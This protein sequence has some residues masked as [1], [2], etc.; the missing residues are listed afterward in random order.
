M[1]LL[2][3]FL[4]LLVSSPVL[5]QPKTKLFIRVGKLY[6][7][8]NSS[9]LTNQQIIVA[10]GVIEAVGHNIV[11]P[12]NATVLNLTT[13]TVTPGLIDMHTH[14]LL[15]QKQTKDGLEVASKVPASE[16]IK[17]GLVFARQHI[18][19]GITTVR[20]LGNSGQ[21]LD[22]Q[23]QKTL[24]ESKEI[25][26][27]MYVSGPI[28]SP[29]G[30]QFSKL[31]PADSFVINQEYRVVS[32]VEDARAAVLEHKKRGV[33][34]IKVCM[35][36]ENRVLAPEEIAAIVQTAHKNG[37]SVTAHATYDDSAKDA[38]LAGVDGI[39]HGYILSDSTLA[40]MA[41]RGTYLVPTDVSREKGELLVAGI[42][43]VGKEAEDYLKSALDGFHDRLRRAVNKGVMIVSGSDFYN[44]VKGI[45][46]GEGAVDVIQSYYEAGLPAK[47][48]LR[49]ATYNAA[50]ALGLSERLGV[51]SKGAKA[52]LV[53]FN[54]DL[55]NDFAQSLANVKMVLKEG[56]I[57]YPKAKPQSKT[58]LKNPQ[59]S[60]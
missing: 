47:D 5:A 42:G 22:S 24:A 10:D 46:R 36:T 14:L 41:Q 2:I 40:L 50:K 9:F 7:A 28:I 48:V 35:N 33:N 51:I 44:D 11:K 18:E 43:M 13:C 60:K 12:A 21:Y 25:G 53:F 17:S 52:D 8:K 26:P 27:T 32:G 45:E 15:H 3:P 49:Y 38:V 6:D 58:K 34:V 57:I 54:G 19:A 20:D 55:E 30:G 29:P 39:E 59:G 56:R 37:L 16:R 1:R 4:L 23:L 31:F